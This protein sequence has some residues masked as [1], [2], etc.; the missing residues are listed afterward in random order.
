VVSVLLHALGGW[1]VP[2]ALLE[3]GVREVLRREGVDEG[4]ISLA[5][6]DDARME[7]LNVEYLGRSGPTDVIAFA[8]HAPGEA[9]LG[10]VYVGYEQARR[11][12][13]RL[14]V[15][16]DEE[17]LRLAVHGTLHVLGHTHPDGE[18]RESSPMYQ[19]QEALLAQILASKAPE[20]WG[21]KE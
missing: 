14:N 2:G 4:E 15:L 7:A 21:A 16:L 12:A 13:E 8:L 17:L 20:A 9:P 3:H 10:D 19:L 5:L 11:Q 1:K 18:E 6:L